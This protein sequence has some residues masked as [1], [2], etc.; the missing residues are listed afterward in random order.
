MAGEKGKTGQLTNAMQKT[1][2]KLAT[3]ILSVY[4][5]TGMT[6]LKAIQRQ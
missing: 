3:A 4:D 1:K 2:L 5:K 6:I